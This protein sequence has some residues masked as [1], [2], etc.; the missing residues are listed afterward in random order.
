MKNNVKKIFAV[1]GVVAGLAFSVQPFRYAWNWMEIKISHQQVEIAEN[2][3][4]AST[5]GN[6]TVATGKTSKMKSW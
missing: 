5:I 3:Y 1:L 6:S 2:R 4:D